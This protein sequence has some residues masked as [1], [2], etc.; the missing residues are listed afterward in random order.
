[1]VSIFVYRSIDRDLETEIRLVGEKEV[2]KGKVS[3]LNARDER[4][5]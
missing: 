1:M 3:I 4:S 2:E 5:Q